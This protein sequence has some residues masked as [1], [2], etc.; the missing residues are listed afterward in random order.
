MT[1]G[2]QVVDS[3]LTPRTD[4]IELV[5]LKR[6]LKSLRRSNS[7]L[8]A[9]VHEFNNQ[10]HAISGMIQ[11]GRH[12]D[13][14]RYIR[15]LNQQD[16]LLEEDLTA[17]VHDSSVSGL[18]MAKSSFAA[19][20]DVVLSLAENTV[21]DLLKPT[22]SID[23]VT[24]IGNLV[25][26][27][28]DAAEDSEERDAWVEVQIQQDG[29]KVEITVRDSG[30]GI[31]H[32]HAQKIFRNGYT[33][34]TTEKGERGFGLALT[35]AICE[36]RGGKLTFTSSGNGTVFRAVLDFALLSEK[37]SEALHDD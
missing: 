7:L 21:L 16:R 22:A 17:R 5:Q 15:S 24:V 4:T 12:A 9:Q 19:K 35:Q 8:R 29:S 27:A 3:L 6:E 36:R 37:Y 23:V 13:V 1:K 2:E 18:L 33:T 30:P 11:M 14:T 20:R 32:E 26:N 28:V 31:A 25:D 10:L 34:K